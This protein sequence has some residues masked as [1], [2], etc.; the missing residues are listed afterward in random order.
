MKQEAPI[1]TIRLSDLDQQLSGLETLPGIERIPAT[2]LIH[3]L[4]VVY[5]LAEPTL[6]PKLGRP[7][8]GEPLYVRP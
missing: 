7:G 1:G 5:G 2:A 8:E 6:P 4:K 3:H